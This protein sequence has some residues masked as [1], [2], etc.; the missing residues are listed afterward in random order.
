MW[1]LSLILSV[2]LYLLNCVCWTILSSLQ[3]N[4]VVVMVMT[5]LMSCWIQFASILMKILCLC[6]SKEIDLLFFLLVYYFLFLSFF[7]F[8]C[9]LLWFWYQG[10]NWLYRMNLLAFLPYLLDGLVWRMLVLGLW[11]SRESIWSWALLCWETLYYCF[12]LIACYRSD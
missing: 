12:N 4:S 9:V 10:N 5:F 8:N 6:S 7:F 2:T 1:L 11:D 3:W